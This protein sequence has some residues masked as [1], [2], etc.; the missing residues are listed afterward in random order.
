[1]EDI[2]IPPIHDTGSK[3]YVFLSF[4]LPIIGL[5]AA[6]IFKHFNH[7]RNYKACRKGAVTGLIVIGAIIVL[8][9]LLL[10]MVVA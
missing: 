5:I 10:W 7:I 1:M 4:L 9:L 6:F 3:W 2:T 8:F